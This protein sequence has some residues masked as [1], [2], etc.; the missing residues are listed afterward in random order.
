MQDFFFSNRI[1]NKTDQEK[2]SMPSRWNVGTHSLFSSPIKARTFPFAGRKLN[3]KSKIPFFR[4]FTNLNREQETN[5]KRALA[6][7]DLPAPKT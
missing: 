3:N 4:I 2:R 7:R 5:L 6:Y 1:I